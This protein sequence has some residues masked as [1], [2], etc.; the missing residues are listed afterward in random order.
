MFKMYLNSLKKKKNNNGRF[1]DQFCI[2]NINFKKLIGSKNVHIKN[3]YYNLMI[4]VILS[5]L[6]TITHT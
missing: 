3:I 5:K 1:V 4:S 6:K 2:L